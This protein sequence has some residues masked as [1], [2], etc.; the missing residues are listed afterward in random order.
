[1]FCRKPGAGSAITVNYRSLTRPYR[2]EA[3]GDP[4]TLQ[5]RFAQTPGGAWWQG[6]R[7]NYGMKYEVSGATQLRLAAD[8]GL[9]VSYATPGP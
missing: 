2:I 6:L 9:T 3:I 8:P 1:M 7:D 4:R 5:A